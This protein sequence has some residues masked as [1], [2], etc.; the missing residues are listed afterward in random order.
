MSGYSVPG[1]T[2]PFFKPDHKIRSCELTTCRQSI[3]G[4]M[5]HRMISVGHHQGGNLLTTI[6]GRGLLDG[7][8]RNVA[9]LEEDALD[10]R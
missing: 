4:G 7:L 10:D 8:M 3:V 5:G 9:R 6:V 1:M 2:R